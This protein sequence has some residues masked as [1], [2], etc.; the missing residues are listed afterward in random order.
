MDQ[1]DNRLSRQT[2]RDVPEQYRRFN[3][4]GWLLVG[5][6]GI[7]EY[8]T[9]RPQAVATQ[10]TVDHPIALPYYAKLDNASG[11]LATGLPPSTAAPYSGNPLLG[12][13]PIDVDMTANADTV[14]SSDVQ[15]SPGLALATLALDASHPADPGE[16]PPNSEGQPPM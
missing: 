7:V 1:E 10:Y 2:A 16:D 9:N 6:F 8:L 14:L 11:V 3:L 5:Q 15:T 12:S 13:A 4:P